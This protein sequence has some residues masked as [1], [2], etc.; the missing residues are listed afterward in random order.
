MFSILIVLVTFEMGLTNFLLLRDA[1]V[2]S[3]Y[4]LSKASSLSSVLFVVAAMNV[5]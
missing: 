5:C 3:S 2:H 4:L 1:Y